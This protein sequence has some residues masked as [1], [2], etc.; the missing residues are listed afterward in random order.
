[1]TTQQCIEL[2][3]VVGMCSGVALC[4]FCSALKAICTDVRTKL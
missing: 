3:V 2:A 1:M 4:M